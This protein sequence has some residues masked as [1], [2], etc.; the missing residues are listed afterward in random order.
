M[1]DRAGFENQCALRGTA[2]SNPALSVLLLLGKPPTH[3]AKRPEYPDP[4]GSGWVPWLRWRSQVERHFQGR[5]YASKH[6]TRAR[7]ICLEP[8]VY[9]VPEP[10]QGGT[11]NVAAVTDSRVLQLCPPHQARRGSSVTLVVGLNKLLRF[12]K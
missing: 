4:A 6:G 11:P 1:A 3:F 9:A 7:C 12:R 10:P 8:R 5:A 2:G